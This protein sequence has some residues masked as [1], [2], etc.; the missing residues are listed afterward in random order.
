MKFIDRVHGDYVANC[1][2]HVLSDHLT[3]IIPDSFQSVIGSRCGDRLIACLMLS[4]V[5]QF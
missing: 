5:S 2:A 3:D 4:Y 1:R